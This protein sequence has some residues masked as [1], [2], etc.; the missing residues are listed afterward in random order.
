MTRKPPFQTK[1][2]L[3]ISEDEKSFPSYFEKILFDRFDFKPY[4]KTS[5]K[6]N[7]VFIKTRPEAEHRDQ[8]F[9]TIHYFSSNPLKIVNHGNLE[10][11]NFDKIYCVFDKRKNGVDATYK[12]AMGW[13]MKSNVTRINSVPNYE[14]WLILHFTDS[15]AGYINDGEAIKKL[16][17]LVR[18]ATGNQKFKYPKSV[19]P[20]ELSKIVIEKLPDA[21]KRAKKIEELNRQ[22]GST[23][24]FTKIYQLMEDFQNNF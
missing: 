20:K 3:I 21:I 18:A 13:T 9:V 15:R 24:P 23:E 22:D 8:I 1:Q 19:L 6:N 10:S 16:E 11:A 14:F 7:K 5:K 12:D 2:I 17:K 4:P